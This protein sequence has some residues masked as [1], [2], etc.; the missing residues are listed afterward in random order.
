[1]ESIGTQTDLGLNAARVDNPD[2]IGVVKS[3]LF[4]GIIDEVAL[5]HAALS[6]AD[7][8]AVMDGG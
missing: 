7:V 6:Q 5:F 3:F 8:Q 2:L 1:M 4:N